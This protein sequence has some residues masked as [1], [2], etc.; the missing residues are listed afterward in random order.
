M[1]ISHTRGTSVM[2]LP[3]PLPNNRESFTHRIPARDHRRAPGDQE[4]LAEPG[5]EPLD[6]PLNKHHFR[7]EDIWV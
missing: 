5:I 2:G 4:G 6:D 1:S 3:E 7:V